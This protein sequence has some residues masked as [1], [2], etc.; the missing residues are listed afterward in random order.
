[1]FLENEIET[2]GALVVF[3]NVTEELYW[4]GYV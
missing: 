1:M 3:E 4:V 2:S